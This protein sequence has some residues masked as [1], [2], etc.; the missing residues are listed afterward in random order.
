[1][2]AVIFVSGRSTGSASARMTK[3]TR[4]R[5]ISVSHQGVR[6]GVRSR[7]FELEEEPRRRKRDEPRA[8]RRQP[9]DQPDQRQRGQ[10]HQ[11]P[12]REEAERADHAAGRSVAHRCLRK[13]AGQP[14]LQEEQAFGGGPVG[15]MD[16][17]GRGAL[18]RK[19]ADQLAMRFEPRAIVVAEAAGAF[20][21]PG[22]AGLRIAEL[23]A[24]LI[25]KRLLGG[26]E[27]LQEVHARAAAGKRAKA[28]A[29]H[30]RLGEEIGEHDDVGEAADAV[31]ARP[32][33]RE[34]GVRQH[35]GQ[36]LGGVA[37][38]ARLGEARDADTLAAAAEHVGKRQ[39]QDHG[40]VEL[41]R[42]P[43][44]ASGNP[45]TARGRPTATPSARL[46]IRARE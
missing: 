21:E 39:H 32:V 25:G 31:D 6:A 7:S 46:P 11:H 22:H 13:A 23:Q 36:P 16:G 26:I 43:K 24:P 44:G 29:R 27:D 28:L 5:R 14:R 2:P 45:S 9:Q 41:R 33:G 12:R 35:L 1:M 37:A 15:V 34:L 40:A 3:A 17:E 10:R 18:A 42:L 38:D 4:R 20:R 8:R 30:L 19:A